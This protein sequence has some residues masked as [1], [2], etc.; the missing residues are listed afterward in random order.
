MCEDGEGQGV[1][2]DVRA[3]ESGLNG[4]V[5]GGVEGTGVGPGS[6][7]D[8]PDGERDGGRQRVGGAVVEAEGER[9]S[10]VVVGIGSVGQI[11][12]GA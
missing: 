8:G 11:R 5:G 1:G 4:S 6:V 3:R 10:T 12:R 7:V 2:F 9:I